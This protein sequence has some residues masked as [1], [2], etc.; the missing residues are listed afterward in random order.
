MQSLKQRAHLAEEA[1]R[2]LE[3]LRKENAELRAQL[4]LKSRQLVGLDDVQVGMELDTVEVR[5]GCAGDRAGR[6]STGLFSGEDGFFGGDFWRGVTCCAARVHACSPALPKV[7]MRA[8]A[9]QG[10]AACPPLADPPTLHTQAALDRGLAAGALGLLA[11]TPQPGADT[12]MQQ[13]VDIM[14]ASEAEQQAAA[15]QAPPP[16]PGLPAL[17]GTSPALVAGGTPSENLVH[18]SPA[19]LPGELSLPTAAAPHLEPLANGPLA[20]GP[21]AVPALLQQAAPQPQHQQALNLALGGNSAQSLPFGGADLP[22]LGRPV[23]ALHPM[24]SI[25]EPALMA[26]TLQEVPLAAGASGAALPPLPGASLPMVNSA[27]SQSVSS[28]SAATQVVAQ[29]AQVAQQAQQAQVQAQSMA[30]AA[31]VHAQKAQEASSSAHHLQATVQAIAHTHTQLVKKIEDVRTTA[32][33]HVNHPAVSSGAT[34]P[35]ALPAS[36]RCISAL[37]CEWPLLNPVRL[38]APLA[39]PSCPRPLLSPACCAADHAA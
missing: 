14:Q 12:E 27:A 32:A 21:P 15:R 38:H 25:S 10:I 18:Q 9:Q 24:G 1:S 30:V 22:L 5:L 39:D 28:L 37:M 8:V 36:G 13:A 20:A 3:A 11:D 26:P 33:A 16:L 6:A 34:L 23:A 19:T 31:H 7:S 29:A 4:Q 2:Q 35:C 17:H